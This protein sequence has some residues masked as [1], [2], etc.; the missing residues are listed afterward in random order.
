MSDTNQK[1]IERLY[2]FQ[3]SMGYTSEG[4]GM[5][6]GLVLEWKGTVLCLK[7]PAVQ[8]MLNSV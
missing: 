3:G 4:K 8:E 6:H 7:G 2:A 1:N 5:T